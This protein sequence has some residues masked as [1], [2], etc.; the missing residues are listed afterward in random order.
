M[1]QDKITADEIIVSWEANPVSFQFESMFPYKRIRGLKFSFIKGAHGAP[2]ALVSAGFNTNVLYRD[3]IGFEELTGSMPFF[4]E[5]YSVDEDTRQELNSVKDEYTDIL[6]SRIFDDTDNLLTSAEVTAERMRAQLV[7]TGTI[8]IVENGVDKQYDYGFDTSK[9]Y[10]DL[11]STGYWSVKDVKP[12][13]SL[14]EQIDAYYDKN[15][16]YPTE[17][18]LSQK[19]FNLLRK[20]SEVLTYFKSLSNPILYPNATQIQN[21]VE[22]LFD[23]K[24]TITTQKYIPARKTSGNETPFYPED[25]IT[26]TSTTNLGNTLYGTTPEE[27]DLMSK[28]TQA[29]SCNTTAKGVAVTTWTTVDPV[30]VSVKVSEVCLPTCPNIDKLYIVKVLA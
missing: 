27:S 13:A 7:A 22:S 15:N 17:M 12:L 19:V 2:V 30:N 1:W 29:D 16:V 26:L 10:K 18:I 25:R 21:Y 14:Q 24:L 9:Q 20:D 23:I 3:R 8:S 5:A 4:K 11:T 28:N 6:L